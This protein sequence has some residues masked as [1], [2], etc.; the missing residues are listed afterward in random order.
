VIPGGATVAA[1]TAALAD[2]GFY[3]KRVV[4][5]P[6]RPGRKPSMLNR[7]WDISGRRYDGLRPIDFHVTVTGH[8]IHDGAVITSGS[9][10]MAV[11]MRAACTSDEEYVRVRG[12]WLALRARLAVAVSGA[13]AAA[14]DRTGTTG[15]TGST[16]ELLGR[17]AAAGRIPSDV[18]AQVITSMRAEFGSPDGSP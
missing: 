2:G 9:T 12:E 3:V 7:Y 17:L 14:E 15:S 11:S 4:E 6:P 8:E 5:N 16:A 10:D 18:A 1:I 13:A